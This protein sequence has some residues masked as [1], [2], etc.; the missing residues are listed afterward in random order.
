[1][2]AGP[3]PGETATGP[4]ADTG[5]TPAWSKPVCIDHVSMHDALMNRFALKT[6]P[7][8]STVL[9]H[10]LPGEEG[11]IFHVSPFDVFEEPVL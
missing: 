4:L 6:P 7:C 3:L 1:M 5:R 9:A 11:D 2:A 8:T 10:A